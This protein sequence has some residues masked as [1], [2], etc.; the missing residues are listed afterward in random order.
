MIYI[1]IIIKDEKTLSVTTDR[2]FLLTALSVIL[3]SFNEF[4]HLIFQQDFL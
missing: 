4:L 2:V 3:F 1:L